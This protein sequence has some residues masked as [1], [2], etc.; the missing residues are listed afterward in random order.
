[1]FFKNNG[2]YDKNGDG[3]L[4]LGERQAQYLDRAG[5]DIELAERRRKSAFEQ[6]VETAVKS[7]IDLFGDAMQDMA[8]ALKSLLSVE[9]DEATGFAARL[10]LCTASD[11]ALRSGRWDECV[12]SAD[13][14]FTSGSSYYPTRLVFKTVLAAFPVCSFEELRDAMGKGEGV[15]AGEMALTETTCGTFWQQL[16]ER[17]APEEEPY[18]L[19]S[20]LEACGDISALFAGN[21][22]AREAEEQRMEDIFKAHWQ[23]YRAEHASALAQHGREREIAESFAEA[24][25]I[26]VLKLI[27]TKLPRV[28]EDFRSGELDWLST[29]TMTD[30]YCETDLDFAREILRLLED[31]GYGNSAEADY[32]RERIA[33]Y[34]G[35]VE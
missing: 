13:G 20:I 12:K 8:D 22:E 2:K 5:I 23:L 7:R 25:E 10:A 30:T 35:D 19:E 9:E 31:E 24:E 27:L 1:M 33:I 34:D 26:P 6:Q 3:R 28:V 15:F 17:A 21:Y 16:M 11:A 4:S 29:D 14:I 18:D 32:L